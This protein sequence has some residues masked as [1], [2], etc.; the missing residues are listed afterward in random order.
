MISLLCIWI[1]N[2]VF[3]KLEVLGN[4]GGRNNVQE[5]ITGIAAGD[6]VILNC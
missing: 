1:S 2:Q 5:E 6:I 3:D 4:L